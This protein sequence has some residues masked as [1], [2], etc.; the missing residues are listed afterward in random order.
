MS[1]GPIKALTVRI[2]NYDITL[3][4]IIIQKDMAGVAKMLQRTSPSDIPKILL[5]VQTKNMACKV[6]GCLISAAFSNSYVGMYHVSRIA[7]TL[8]EG[9]DQS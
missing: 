2:I 3:K 6:Y 7:D 8:H 9:E 1:V 5:F 4:S